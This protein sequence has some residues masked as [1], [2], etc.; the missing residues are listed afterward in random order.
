MKLSSV[1]VILANWG[2]DFM[3]TNFGYT[4]IENISDIREAIVF[5]SDFDSDVKY[6]D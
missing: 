6:K 2:P 4:L 1:T 5:F 3:K